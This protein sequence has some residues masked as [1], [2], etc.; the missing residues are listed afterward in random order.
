MSDLRPSEDEGDRPFAVV[1]E[2]GRQHMGWAD[3]KER[4]LDTESEALARKVAAEGWLKGAERPDVQAS[5]AGTFADIAQVYATLYLAEQLRI[6]NLIAFEQVTGEKNRAEI[7][8][9]LGL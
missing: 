6:S 2:Y 4:E 5:V 9:G 8:K 7:R 1:A 3:D